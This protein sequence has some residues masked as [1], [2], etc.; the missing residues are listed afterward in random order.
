MVKLRQGFTAYKQDLHRTNRNGFVLREDKADK[1]AALLAKLLADGDFHDVILTGNDGVEV[2][3][4][5][6]VLSASSPVFKAMLLG[7]FSEGKS[8]KVK[9]QEYEGAVLKAVVEFIH[10]DEPNILNHNNRT[11]DGEDE[12]VAPET[13]Q[14]WISLA[15]AAQF[16]DLPDL[17]TK[18]LNFLRHT[19]VDQPTHLS[20]VLLEACSQAGPTISED[21]MEF[22]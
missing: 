16:F 6:A 21:Y 15:T 4:C 14:Q 13:I 9:I 17:N 1:A 7:K 12:D 3:A 11:E 10:T 22:A 19:L 18:V 5:R 8:D 20:S 2:T